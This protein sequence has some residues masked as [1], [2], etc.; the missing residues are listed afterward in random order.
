MAIIF[1]PFW[2]LYPENPIPSP[3]FW[4][5][6]WS[7]R[8][9]ARSDRPSNNIAVIECQI[10]LLY[11]ASSSIL[12]SF[13]EAEMDETILERGRA[14]RVLDPDRCRKAVFRSAHTTRAM[15]PRRTVEI[16]PV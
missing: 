15:R 6:Y 2:C 5:R 8:H 1:S 12:N 11:I 7:R 3:P 16:F 13:L 10:Q 9:G 4:P 14:R